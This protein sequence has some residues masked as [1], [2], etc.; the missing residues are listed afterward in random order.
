MRSR[1]TLWGKKREARLKAEDEWLEAPLK[2]ISTQL[3]ELAR[4][5]VERELTSREA[6]NGRLAG[7]ITFAG[8]L[9]ALALTLGQRAAPSAARHQARHAVFTVGLI[10]AVVMLALAIITAIRGLRPEPRHHTSIKLLKHYGVTGTED[11][12]P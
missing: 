5:T 10:T 12:E 11:Q 7:T 2:P 6:L 9:P 1:Q 8:A 4:T 3:Q